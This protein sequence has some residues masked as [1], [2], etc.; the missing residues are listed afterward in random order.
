MDYAIAVMLYLITG[1]QFVRHQT[2]M[3]QIKDWRRASSFH[4]LLWPFFF[5]LDFLAFI[6][7]RIIFT[8]RAIRAAQRKLK[9]A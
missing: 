8:Y 4:V 9:N 7:D 6:W 5:A 3:E 1:L 2:Y